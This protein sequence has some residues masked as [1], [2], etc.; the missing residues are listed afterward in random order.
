[1]N[2]AFELKSLLLVI[3]FYKA[4]LLNIINYITLF[5][6]STISYITIFIYLFIFWSKMLQYITSGTNQ[7]PW[8]FSFATPSIIDMGLWAHNRPKE[9]RRA[10]VLIYRAF[11]ILFSRKL[12]DS[13]T[14]VGSPSVC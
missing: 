4:S 1:M 9:K 8:A 12:L 11:L 2:S 3:L 14:S 13:S 10:L 6:G 5:F 7:P